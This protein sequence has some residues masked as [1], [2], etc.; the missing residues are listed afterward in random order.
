MN[1]NAR[2][3]ED[4]RFYAS[5]FTAALSGICANPDFF[6]AV[7]QGSPKAAAEFAFQCVEAAMQLKPTNTE[8]EK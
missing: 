4:C 7:M 6:G 5:V 8:T 2:I 1:D 3:N